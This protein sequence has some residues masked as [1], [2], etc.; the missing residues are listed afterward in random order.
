MNLG[1]RYILH[2]EPALPLAAAMRHWHLGSGY[3]IG[4]PEPCRLPVVELVE[5]ELASI[6]SIFRAEAARQPS[7][8]SMPRASYEMNCR[9][10]SSPSNQP[11]RQVIVSF[12]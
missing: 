6:E 1:H 3:A 10:S 4:T 2:I 11:E 9:R 5:R 8:I 7:G 12:R